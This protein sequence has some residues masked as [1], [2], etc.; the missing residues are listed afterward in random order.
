MSIASAV[1]DR[2]A[3]FER[4]DNPTQG[5]GVCATPLAGKQPPT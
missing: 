2:E 3:P 5:G 4:T 1:R